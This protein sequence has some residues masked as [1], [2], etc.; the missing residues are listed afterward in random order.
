MAR[1]RSNRFRSKNSK[2]RPPVIREAVA[3]DELLAHRQRL[4]GLPMED[5][6]KQRAGVPLETLASRKL[7]TEAQRSAGEQYASL[8]QRWRRMHNI[9]DGNRQ[10]AKGGVGVELDPRKVEQV[11][12]AMNAV[13]AELNNTTALVRAVLD[14]VCVDEEVG[15]LLDHSGLGARLLAALQDG[16]TALGRVF[17]TPAQRAA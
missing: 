1:K 2:G 6:M 14:S 3:T 5:L 10:P 9:P 16:L 8:V 4:T 17:K 13:L 11:D 15:R 12:A 7:I